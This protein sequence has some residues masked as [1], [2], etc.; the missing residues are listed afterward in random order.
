MCNRL[1][2]WALLVKLLTGE[3]TG[4]TPQNSFDDKSTFVQVPLPE[5]MLTWIYGAM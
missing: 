2:S 4:E 5:P 1:S 3:N